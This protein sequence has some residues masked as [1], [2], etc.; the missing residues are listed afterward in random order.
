MKTSLTKPGQPGPQF[1]DRD[2]RFG[3]PVVRQRSAVTIES[4]IFAHLMEKL[5]IVLLFDC[6]KGHG[7]RMTRLWRE[8]QIFSN[9]VFAMSNGGAAKHV[10]EQ[11]LVMA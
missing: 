1:L 7:N 8:T 9:H 11:E 5:G 6:S 3:I 2:C 10:P 4:T